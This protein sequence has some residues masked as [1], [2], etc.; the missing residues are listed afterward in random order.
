MSGGLIMPDV[1]EIRIMDIL[2]N[3]EGR[4][5]DCE[6]KITCGVLDYIDKIQCELRK[7]DFER[8]D[9]FI[10]PL[11]LIV[12]NGRIFRAIKPS[13]IKEDLF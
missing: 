3:V 7:P 8:I 1:K 2:E 13:D 9:R 5:D 6:L 11:G 12:I 10:C 4:C